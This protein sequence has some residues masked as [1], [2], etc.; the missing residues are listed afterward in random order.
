M[1]K[2]AILGTLIL[3][4]AG[5]AGASDKDCKFTQIKAD[6][7]GDER[8]FSR[9]RSD[10]DCEVFASFTKKEVASYV[11]LVDK[12]NRTFTL[13]GL[14][15]TSMG[16]G[17]AL[18]TTKA[19]GVVVTFAKQ[20]LQTFKAPLGQSGPP[21]AGLLKGIIAKEYGAKTAEVF[22][23]STYVTMGTGIGSLTVPNVR[24][25]VSDLVTFVLNPVKEEYNPHLTGGSGPLAAACQDE[26][27][28]ELLSLKKRIELHEDFERREAACNAISGPQATLCREEFERYKRV[29]RRQPSEDRIREILNGPSPT[30][31]APK[32]PIVPPAR[33]PGQ[34]PS[35]LVG[36][37]LR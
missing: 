2:S 4:Y 19:G 15:A 24:D 8:V 14:L 3:F 7:K 16:G 17:V 33:P 28:A 35:E 27:V 18:Q 30:P 29:L 31:A 25:K 10:D 1:D 32:A 37:A 36:D 26:E 6:A 20:A 12:K 11:D 23:R 13:V 21:A 5:A 22:S 34:D 9:C